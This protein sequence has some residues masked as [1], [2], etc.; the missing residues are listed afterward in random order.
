MKNKDEVLKILDGKLSKKESQWHKEAEFRTLNKKWLKRS[1]AVAFKILQT[2]REQ[3]ISQKELASR[4]GLKPQQ[5]NNWVKGKSNFT[6][7]TVAK[8][9]AALGIELM[10]IPLNKKEEKRTPV[11]LDVVAA[12]YVATSAHSTQMTRSSKISSQIMSIG[13]LTTWSDNT[14]KYAN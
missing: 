4:M 5:I 13:G 10:N 6:F 8:I 9:E 2:I 14:Q 7:E 3:G 11:S 12:I 1:Q